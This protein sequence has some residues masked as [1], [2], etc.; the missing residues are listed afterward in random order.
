MNRAT[1]QSLGA[2][3]HEP[4]VGVILASVFALALSGVMWMTGQL[5]GLLWSGQWPASAVGEAPLIGLRLLGHLTDPRAAWPPSAQTSMPPAVALYALWALLAMIAVLAARRWRGQILVAVGA[6]GGVIGRGTR[7][8]FATAWQT[9]RALGAPALRK[10]LG[11]IRPSLAGEEQADL[12]DAG[13]YLGRSVGGG[14]RMWGTMEDSYL[15]VGPPRCGKGVSFL[16]PTLVRWPGPAVVTSTRDDVFQHTALV[17]TRTGPVFLF[18]PTEVCA[19]P[20]RVRWSPVEGCD[21]PLVAILRARAFVQGS[22]AGKNV[23][24]G[25]FWSGS[26]TTVLRCYLHAAAI[27][28]RDMRTVLRWV[29]QQQNPEP[30]ELLRTSP[31]AAAWAADLAG[32]TQA[33]EQPRSAIFASVGL[34]LAV[35]ADPRVLDAC[36]PDEANPGFDPAVMRQ[37]RGTL[38]VIAHSGAQLSMAPLI[39][40]LVETV[41]DDARR[42]AALS[43]GGRLDP[44]L[45]LFL[46]EASQIAPLPSLP[47]LTADGG[48]SGI[49]TFT[50]LQSEA[51]ARDRWGDEAAAA[52]WDA[53]TVRLLFSGLGNVKDLEDVSRLIGDVDEVTTSVSWG[54]SQ[55][56]WNETAS[57]RRVPAM[58]VAD[59]RGIAKWRP[60]LLYRGL[61][62]VQTS[63]PGWF[64]RPDCREIVE[65]AQRAMECALAGEGTGMQCRGMQ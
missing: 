9:Y 34:A 24:N 11:V 21:D 2:G 62:A 13:V 8:G 51:Q 46:D 22:G 33:H 37:Q 31:T 20:H 28:K 41:V 17:S 12:H 25:D 6:L 39:A 49:T 35:L 63:L 3:G 42:A 58:P 43:P 38:Y 4:L 55:R 52:I 60:L 45:G 44:P 53:S 5:A 15:L 40:A 48:G 47:S 54:G 26:A 64:D 50:V 30:A 29:A 10:S 59:I 7:P 57:L 65:P 19:W 61:R 32:V 16:I 18:D 1:P 56:E 14:V 36:C 27:G 23:T